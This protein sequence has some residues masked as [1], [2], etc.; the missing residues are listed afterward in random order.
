MQA[1]LF[2]TTPRECC[3]VK[4]STHNCCYSAWR[5]PSKLY[6]CIARSYS[7][8]YDLTDSKLSLERTK[9][10]RKHQEFSPC[11]LMYR[12]S[13]ALFLSVAFSLSSWVLYVGSCI[14]ILPIV[15]VYSN[16][17]SRNIKTLLVNSCTVP[18]LGSWD[19][20]SDLRLSTKSSKAFNPYRKQT[21]RH[22]TFLSISGPDIDP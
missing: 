11:L 18:S 13:R 10:K 3:F 16:N 19:T 17:C 12:P 1:L 21:K 20:A 14:N 4:P 22:K 9:I 5:W 15:S 2:Y 6:H 8:K 7:P